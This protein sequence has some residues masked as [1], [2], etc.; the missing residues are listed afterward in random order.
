MSDYAIQATEVS[1]SYRIGKLKAA[2]HTAREA[3]QALAASFLR[4]RREKSDTLLWALKDV[5]FTIGQGEV[6]GIVGKNGSGK[7]TLLKIMS[8]ITDPTAGKIHLRGRV[9]SLLEV[10][11]GFHPDLTGRENVYFNGAILGMRKEEINRRFDEIIAFSEIE[12]FIDTPVKYYSSGM[13]VR[14]GFSVAAH[15]D[16]DIM[17]VDEVLSVGDIAF[18]KKCIGRME[19]IARSGRTIVVVSH[20]MATMKE[21]CTRAMLLHQGQVT[22]I[23]HID[24]VMEEYLSQ[25]ALE[26]NEKIIEHSNDSV[27]LENKMAIRRIKLEQGAGQSFR[28]YWQQAVNLSVDLEI[29]TPMEDVRF[30]VYLRDLAGNYLITAYNDHNKGHWQ[31]RP[32]QYSVKIEFENCLKPGLYLLGLRA[33]QGDPQTNLLQMED[34]YLEILEVSSSGAGS[35]PKNPALITGIRSEFLCNKL[36]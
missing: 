20:N 1:K 32:G 34:L 6:F 12:R 26:S 23:G 29:F 3:L 33:H 16:P 8:R 21:L 35:D 36:L 9:G 28:V 15:F 2:H 4:N 30:G 17:L 25:H 24:Q 11:T 31:L 27:V 22:K 10:G 13:Y 14:L 5:G 19:N 18:Q 7:S